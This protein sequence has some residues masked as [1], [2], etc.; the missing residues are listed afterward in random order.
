MQYEE[1]VRYV[2][3]FEKFGMQPGLLRIAALC[4]ALGDPQQGMRFIH[5]AGTNGKGSTST[6]LANICI[7]AGYRTGLYVSPYVLDFRE[8]FQID[9]RMVEKD[10]FARCMTEVRAAVQKMQRGGVS[11]TEFELI[12]AAAF[13]IFRRAQCDVVVLETGLGGR[14]DA[15]NV[16]DCPLVNV[17]AS[18]SFDHMAILGDTLEKIAAEKCGTLKDGGV[19]VSYPLQP[20]EVMRVIR[21]ICA[22]KNDLL[23]VP[24]TGSVAVLHE[25]V[26]GTDAHIDGLDVHIPMLGRHMVYNAC[27]AVAAARALNTRGLCVRDEHIREGIADSR[28]PARMEIVREQPLV[29]MDGGHNEDCARALKAALERFLAGRRIVGVCGLMADKAY[30]TYLSLVAP[31]FQSIVTVRPDNPRALSAEALCD[32]AKRYCL[33]C[34]A[35]PSFR[36]AAKTA[37]EKAGADGVI[38]VCGS[39]YMIRDLETYLK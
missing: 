30:E 18:V 14:L 36:D 22:Q 2:H 39:F 5:V 11:P 6:M 34:S 38:V 17:I 4:R 7:R 37:L 13:L 24:D 19:C 25:D 12:T 3:T 16:I 20:Q 35:A 26:R 8:R 32:S 28:M 29:L 27:T 15:T 1:A 33:D 10:L 23:I 9:G 21:E 31:L